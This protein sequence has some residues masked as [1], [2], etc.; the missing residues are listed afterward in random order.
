ME[1]HPV[2]LGLTPYSMLRDHF[3]PS[4]GAHIKCNKDQ[5]QVGLFQGK[6][7]NYC[8]IVYAPKHKEDLNN[9]AWYALSNQYMLWYFY[10]SMLSFQE[11]KSMISILFSLFYSNYNSTNTS[12]YKKMPFGNSRKNK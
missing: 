6:L 4:I 11:I 3:W 9:N 1:L 5:S 10:F 2:V 7:H 8:T 12:D